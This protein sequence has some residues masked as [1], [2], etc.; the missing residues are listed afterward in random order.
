MLAGVAVVAVG[1][2]VVMTQDDDGS[3]DGGGGGGG[4]GQKPRNG[5]IDGT[6]ENSHRLATDGKAVCGTGIN[7]TLFC[8]DAATGDERW[9]TELRSDIAGSPTIVD[10]LVLAADDGKSGRDGL[11]AYD[12]DGKQVWTARIDVHDREL[13]PLW[14][15]VAGDTV[16][17][18]DAGIGVPAELIGTD[19]ATGKELWQAFTDHEDGVAQISN[20]SPVL[21]DG[22][23]FYVTTETMPDFG[24]GDEPPLGPSMTLV[25]IDPKTGKE[26]WS[27]VIT[28]GST[29]FP[30]A[31]EVAAFD[32]GS[33]TAFII[34]SGGGPGNVVV[35]DSATG[36]PRWDVPLTS[37]ES[38]VAHAGGVTVVADDATMHGYAADGKELWEKPVPDQLGVGLGNLIV[39]EGRVFL[40][41][42]DVVEINPTS[43][44]SAKVAEGVSAADVVIAGDRLV[45]S[46]MSDI[47]AMPLPDPP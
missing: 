33:A 13:E 30:V 4:D 43:G 12:L 21:S 29:S 36:K 8:Y 46:T 31:T 16:A 2:V 44:A 24:P 3:D 10:G 37:P 7:K 23:R 28:E 47:R 9:A 22:A 6:R 27:Y 41:S 15:P 14:V 19:V 38:T 5:W 45:L 17:A 39:R 26:V 40:A 11:Y 25:A 42:Y 20:F 32:D 35:L 18:I 34:Q 1:A